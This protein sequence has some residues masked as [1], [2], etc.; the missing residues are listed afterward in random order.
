MKVQ[1]VILRVI[2]KKITGDRRP[3]FWESVNVR[4]GAGSSDMR[5]M[6]SDRCSINSRASQVVETCK[7][8]GKSRL[9]KYLQPVP[10]VFQNGL[11][12]FESMN[13]GERI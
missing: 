3:K 9:Q 13:R 11:Y 1:E 8:V 5:N 12:L 6:V 10:E 4:C 2:A 7:S